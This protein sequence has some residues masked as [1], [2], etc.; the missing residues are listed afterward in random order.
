MPDMDEGS[1]GTSDA[2]RIRAAYGKRRTSI[3][4]ERYSMRR[5]GN[6]IAVEERER[7]L[8]A[9]LARRGVGRLA[10]LDILEVGCGSG[11]ELARLVSLGADPQRLHGIDLLEHSAAAARSAVP[12]A[13]IVVADAS[14]LPYADA[15]F[16]LTY[17]AT[18]LSSM[19]SPLM[20]TAV[21]AEMQRVT[22]PGGLIVSYDFAWN[23]TNRDTVG[24][25][26]REL[27][28]LFPG[29]PLEIHRATLVPPLGRWMG[30]RSVRLTRM[31]AAVPILKSHRLAFIDV[32]R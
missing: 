1:G 26:S 17:Q 11:G 4:P 29:L 24:I 13:A 20:R 19:T 10:D 18:A 5:P 22:R 6:R 8:L 25:T 7:I 2:D 15:T 14:E 9:A 28:R 12:G 23:P 21:A 16:D 3:D 30:D 32:V 31:A 27:R